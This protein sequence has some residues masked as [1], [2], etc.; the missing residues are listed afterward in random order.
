MTK[1]DAFC[2][3]K[4]TIEFTYSLPNEN[5]TVSETFQ[6]PLESNITIRERAFLLMKKHNLEQHLL[7]DLLQKLETCIDNEIDQL[8]CETLARRLEHKDA[9]MAK[10]RDFWQQVRHDNS[11]TISQAKTQQKNFHD[12]NFYLMYHQIVHSGILTP[13]LIQLENHNSEVIRNLLRERDEFLEKLTREQNQNVESILLSGSYSDREINSITKNNILLAE[14]RLKEWKDVIANVRSDQKREFAAWVKNTYEDLN[15]GVATTGHVGNPIDSVL[16]EQEEEEEDQGP[17][18][19]SYTINLGAQLKTTHNLRLISVDMNKFCKNICTPQRIQ[20][21]MSLYSNSLSAVVRLVDNCL[22]NKSDFAKSCSNASENHFADFDVQMA[23]I[24]ADI[25]RAKHRGTAAADGDYSRLN[26]GEA[27][28]TKHSNLSEAHV[29]FHLVTDDT[30]KSPDINSRHPV[31]LGL[32][33]VLKIAYIYDIAHISIPLLLLHDMNEDI[34]IQWCLRRAELVLK[35]VK[36]FMIEMS[37]LLSLNDNENKTIQFVVPKGISH[38][39]FSSLSAIFPS[40]F[41]LS[42]TLFLTTNNV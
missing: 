7:P 23:H 25:C 14:K 33:N 10:C 2:Y 15:A 6:L 18:E 19:E 29:V 26:T 1:M 36:G 22:T 35:C 3:P 20:T 24:G 21:A 16:V 40:V 32:R 5:A 38:E 4:Q 41:R 31:I 17:M 42:N 9:L 30:V 8:Q 28:I 37:S 13:Q 12:E 39:L 11:E 27:Y 34:T